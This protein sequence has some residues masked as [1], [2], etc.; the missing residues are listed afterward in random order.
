MSSRN[1]QKSINMVIQKINFK[2]QKEIFDPKVF[3]TSVTVAGLGNI[4][5]QTG[6]ALARLGI[7]EFYLFDQDIV[8]EH[9]LSSQGYSIRDLKKL[10]TASLEQIIK[11]I[12]DKVFTSIA[13]NQKFNGDYC[14]S[15]VLIIA[16]DSMKERKRICQNLKKS[17]TKPKFI[18]DGR[19]GGAQLEIYSC[20]TL[21][22]WESTF[23]DN[24]SRDPCGARYICYISM[25]IGAL[26]ANQVKRYLKGESYKKEIIFNINT[27]QLI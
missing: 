7:R 10:K 17:E 11:E 15:Q 24:P 4:G 13:G 16:V 14:F 6:I 12:N 25:I 20:Q 22:E 1:K 21:E 27:L 19:M 8:E 5:S 2:R 18:I 3:N 23:V 9:N 26:I